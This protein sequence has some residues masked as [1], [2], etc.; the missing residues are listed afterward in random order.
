[1]HNLKKGS[2]V[3][4]REQLM[5]VREISEDGN[6]YT[7]WINGKIIEEGVF[8]KDI[9]ELCDQNLEEKNDF[10]LIINIKDIVNLRLNGGNYPE[11]QVIDVDVS[12]GIVECLYWVDK[13][14]ITIKFYKEQLRK[15]KTPKQINRPRPKEFGF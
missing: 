2:I 9:L 5:S 8:R 15:Q 13:K 11:F 3:K 12:S 10:N 4:S 14:N 7:N 6:V 1:M